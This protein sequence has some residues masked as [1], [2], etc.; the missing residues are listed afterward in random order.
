MKFGSYN[1]DNSIVINFI[2]ITIAILITFLFVASSSKPISSSTHNLNKNYICWEWNVTKYKKLNSGGFEWVN[3]TPYTINRD[4]LLYNFYKFKFLN[5]NNKTWVELSVK[6][7]PS[8]LVKVYNT[9]ILR[10]QNREN[11]TW[12]I[13]VDSSY[14]KCLKKIKV[15]E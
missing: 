8:M 5:P 1:I 12:G 13:E 11:L 7:N 14:W 4:E 10:Y 9:S 6:D 15:E 3:T 2:I